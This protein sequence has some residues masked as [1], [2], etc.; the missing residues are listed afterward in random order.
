MKHE[1]GT[2]CYAC[3][4]DISG[5]GQKR[6]LLVARWELYEDIVEYIESLPLGA[7]LRRAELVDRFGRGP[8]VWNVSYLVLRD[9]RF[10][11]ILHP[12]KIRWGGNVMSYR[13]AV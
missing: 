9:M 7:I 13:K 1:R 4:I 10:H 2:P 11:G 5:R 6:E 8:T 3:T 12:R